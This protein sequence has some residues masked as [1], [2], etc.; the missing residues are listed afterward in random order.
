MK[1]VSVARRY[2]RALLEVAL[3]N[4]TADA[5]LAALEAVG[6]AWENSPALVDVFV[7]PAYPRAQRKAVLEQLLGQLGEVDPALANAFRLLNDRAR[8]PYVP[9]IAR[10]FRD[11]ADQKAG[12]VRGKVT[13]AVHLAPDSVRRLEKTLETLTDR[14][15]MLEPKVDPKVLG[16]ASAQIGSQVFDGTLRSQLEDL[17]RHLKG[18]A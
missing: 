7:N 14:K 15:V 17:R 12:R 2:A 11:M 3:E 9:S 4:G 1:N 10:L 16:G 13:T 5:M 18:G 6:R 8:L